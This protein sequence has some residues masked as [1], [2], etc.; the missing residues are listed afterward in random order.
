MNPYVIDPPEQPRNPRPWKT[1]VLVATVF[2]AITYGTLAHGLWG[3]FAA[4]V[5]VAVVAFALGDD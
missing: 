5:A 1:T 4:L 3:Y 2:A